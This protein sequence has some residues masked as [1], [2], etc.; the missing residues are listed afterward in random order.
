MDLFQFQRDLGRRI[1]LQRELWEVQAEKLAQMPDS[2]SL[3][4]S[5]ALVGLLGANE[6]ASS[7]AAAVAP[8]CSVLHHQMCLQ[9][10]PF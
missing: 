9:Q 5:A 6:M 3:V 7:E 8:S 2:G 1:D 4:Q 10:V